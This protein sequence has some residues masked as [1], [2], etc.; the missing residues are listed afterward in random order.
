MNKD[1]R[2]SDEIRNKRTVRQIITVFSLFFILT[3]ITGI[4]S[5]SL[6]ANILKNQLVLK[7]S[8][9]AST[10]ASVIASDSDGYEEFLHTLDMESDYYKR[11]KELLMNIKRANVNHVTYIYTEARVDNDMMMYVIGGEDPSS[12]VYTAP[13]VKDT[14]V[15]AN[16][17]AYNKQN[18]ITGTNFENTQYGVRLSAYAPIIHKNSGVF[19][20]LV[21]ADI[22]KIQYNNVM[23]IFLFQAI[24]GF[25]IG[26]ILFGLILRFFSGSLRRTINT[27]SLTK[28]YNKAYFKSEL[29]QRTKTSVANYVIMADLDHFKSINDTYGHEFGDKVLALTAEQI[30]KC[31]RYEDCSARYGGEEF[32]SCLSGISDNQVIEIMERIR[33]QVENVLILH[34]ETNKNIPITISIGGANIPEGT[35]V[36]EAIQLADKAL[37]IAKKKR[38]TCVLLDYERN[39]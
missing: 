24:A 19:L 6:A 11:T 14:L 27:D 39:I 34:E 29:K 7:C 32:V 1:R 22:T 31:T 9:L 5:Y 12:P 18:L 15:P 37:Y 21:G 33:T 30:M 2:S 4:I 16:R 38:N 26:L 28:L 3:F 25:I 8:A 35:N 20:G 17:E 13:G 10:V 23:N 36:T